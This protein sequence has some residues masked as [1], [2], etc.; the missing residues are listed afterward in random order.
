[1]ATISELMKDKAPGSIKIKAADWDE[2]VYFVP[3]FCSKDC[4]YGVTAKG[5]YVAYF[6]R[7]HWDIYQEPAA[8]VIRYKYAYMARGESWMETTVFF[9]E[10]EVIAQLDSPRLHQNRI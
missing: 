2:A 7:D 4:W 10:N 1:M 3:Y 8:K 9:K 5:N 6:N